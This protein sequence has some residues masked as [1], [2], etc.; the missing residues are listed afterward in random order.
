MSR[1]SLN[2]FL[3]QWEFLKFPFP[4]FSFP[5]YFGFKHLTACEIS[6]KQT[7]SLFWTVSSS[8]L[9]LSPLLLFFLPLLAEVRQLLFGLVKP[10]RAPAWSSLLS[11]GA[12]SATSFVD[13]P[14]S[15]NVPHQI[16][17]MFCWTS[18]WLSVFCSVW[19]AGRWMMLPR[20]PPARGSGGGGGK[21]WASL[22][23]AKELPW[24]VTSM[25][26]E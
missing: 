13:Q 22:Q 19:R 4:P 11:A 2:L 1:I 14:T 7:A 10:L 20:A 18:L 23:V 8:S 16:T 6:Q 24:T 9:S 12:Q 21:L 15:S 26:L 25:S 3:S 5:S 17:L